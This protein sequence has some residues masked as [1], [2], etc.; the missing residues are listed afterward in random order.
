MVSRRQ[1]FEEGHR[2]K[3]LVVIDDTDECDK[4]VVYG[5]KRAERTGGTLTMLIVVQSAEFQ[6]WLGVADIMREE[7]EEEARR[8]C[9]RHEDRAR[10]VAPSVELET[11]V[12]NGKRA[13]EILGLIEEDPDVGILVLAAGV[14]SDGPG[15]LVNQIAGKAAATYPIPVT[16]VP[17]SLSDDQITALA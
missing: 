14:G 10:S 3:F 9:A 13:D 8:V 16:I 7:A 2:R 11:V 1:S 6:H 12:R 15:P 4:A 17:G 5:A